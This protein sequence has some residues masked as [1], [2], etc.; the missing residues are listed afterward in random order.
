ME[1]F[2]I[3]GSK[4][5]DIPWG[6]LN[7]SKVVINIALIVLSSADAIMAIVTDDKSIYAVHLY[8]PVIKI[9]TFVSTNYFRD[10]HNN[11]E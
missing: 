10:I 1:I 4:N 2:Y 9:A 6:F 8:S 11:I 5:R 3:R 7:V